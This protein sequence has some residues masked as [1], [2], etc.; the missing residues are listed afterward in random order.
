MEFL[1][2]TVD[3]NEVTFKRVGPSLETNIT[4]LDRFRYRHPTSPKVKSSGSVS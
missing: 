4:Y 1:I 3:A 2:L